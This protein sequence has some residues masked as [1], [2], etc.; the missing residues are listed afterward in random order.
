M[1][2]EGR[3]CMEE[4]SNRLVRM[5]VR[6]RFCCTSR[7]GACG[8]IRKALNDYLALAEEVDAE[9]G[10]RPICVPKMMG[11]D[12]DMRNWSFFMLLEHHVIV[13][14]VITKTMESLARG[15]EPVIPGVRDSKKDVMPSGG[16]GPEQ[17]AV[18][19]DTVEEH[20]RVVSGLGRMRGTR[21]KR[22]PIFGEFDAHRWHCMFGFHLRIHGK[23]ADC[24]VRGG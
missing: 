9:S 3:V 12:E 6:A 16:A 15:E 11:V 17:V 24:I 7:E 21:T 13:N 20:L 23:Q 19:R 8:Q 2:S 14:R 4:M 5:A 18:F 22:H 1:V 10:V